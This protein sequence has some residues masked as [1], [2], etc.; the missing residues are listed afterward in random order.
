MKGDAVP[1]M[2]Y[3]AGSKNRFVIPVYQRNYN[4][5]ET[6]CKRLFDD[7]LKVIKS[8]FR[9]HFLGSIVSVFNKNG[10]EYE[11]LVIDGQQRITT[12][13]LILLAIYNLLR[14]N[15]I[16]T[17]DENL[18]NLIKNEYLIDQ[19]KNVIKLKLINKDHE[20]LKRLFNDNKAD[21]IKDSRVTVNYE[22][23]YKRI[24]NENLQPDSLFRALN[25]LEIIDIQLEY[26]YNQQ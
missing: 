6:H 26:K 20:A 1:L 8:K 7:L 21:Y 9:Q 18:I 23:F 19:Y 5:N 17:R 10:G 13:S 25:C 16:K 15:I 11:F 24:Q 2:D 3:L 14:E 22:Y 4:W 12:V